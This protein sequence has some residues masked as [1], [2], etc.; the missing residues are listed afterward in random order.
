MKIYE[1]NKLLCESEIA[2]T[3][4]SFHLAEK[5]KQLEFLSLPPGNYKR[6][7]IQKSIEDYTIRLDLLKTIQNFADNKTMEFVINFNPYNPF[8]SGDVYK[9][10]A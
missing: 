3:W 7:A 8:S 2:F 1:N 10:V 9:I 6:N 4:L 5:V